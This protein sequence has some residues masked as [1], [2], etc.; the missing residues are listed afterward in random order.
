MMILHKKETRE[1]LKMTGLSV[2]FLTCTNCSHGY[3][4]NEWKRFL[5]KTNHENRSVSEKVTRQSIVVK[6]SIN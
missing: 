3:Y 2:Y 1:T 6:Q 4:K 5:M